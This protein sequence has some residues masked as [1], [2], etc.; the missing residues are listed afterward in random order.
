MQKSKRARILLFDLETIPNLAFV[1]GKFEQNVIAFKK[2]WEILCFSWKWLG[3]KRIYFAKRG[4]DDLNL[5]KILHTLFKEADILIAHNGAKF[6]RKKA[7]ARFIYHGLTPPKITKLVDTCQIARNHFGFNSN[8]LNDL[9]EHLKLGK[10]METGGFQLWLDCM[11]NKASAWEKMRRYNKMDVELLE[12]IYLKFLPWVTNHP[13]IS[14]INGEPKYEG[15][16]NCGSMNTIKRG[17]HANRQGLQQQ[18]SCNDCGGY[19][20]VPLKRE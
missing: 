9:G 13:N 20:L 7:N 10:K 1:W 15:C 3:E 6:D 2:E 17:I 4:R 14:M 11:A 16:P 5:V 19:F 8:S 12:K 18:K